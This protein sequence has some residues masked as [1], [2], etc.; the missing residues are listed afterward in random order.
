MN[1]PLNKG[2]CLFSSPGASALLHPFSDLIND[3]VWTRLLI[4]CMTIWNIMVSH[5]IT[6]SNQIGSWRRHDGTKGP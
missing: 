4:D 3:K 2:K 6:E 1:S 5:L